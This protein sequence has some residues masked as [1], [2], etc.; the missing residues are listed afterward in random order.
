MSK[1]RL[2]ENELRRLVNESLVELIDEGFLGNV[3][4]AA[5]GYFSQVKDNLVQGAKNDW[6]N[7]KEGWNNAFNYKQN[8]ERQRQ[9]DILQRQNDAQQKEY[10]KNNQTEKQITDF[11][12]IPCK[13]TIKGGK[14]RGLNQPLYIH[15]TAGN[16]DYILGQTDFIIPNS[17]LYIRN[18]DD[19]NYYYNND[20][21]FLSNRNDSQIYKNVISKYVN[22]NNQWINGGNKEKLRNALK[23]YRLARTKAWENMYIKKNVQGNN[24]ANPLQ[25]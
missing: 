21:L 15:D 22:Q 14:N 10:E 19:Y 20:R 8:R 18:R 9:K 24:N 23:I 2:T 13:E 6:D 17:N 16:Y 5:G 4:Q 3:A 11:Y 7:A 25:Y 12:G 1:I